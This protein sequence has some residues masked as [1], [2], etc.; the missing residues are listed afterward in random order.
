M[1][2]ARFPPSATTTPLST[3]V[4]PPLEVINHQNQNG[5]IAIIA[6]F[7]FGLVL[8]SASIKVF[9]RQYFR[10]FRH[11]DITF[12]IA[13]V[14]ARYSRCNRREACDVGEKN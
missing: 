13:I 4:I 9:A 12:A 1:S 10:N 5:V 2:I 6:G 11:D 8:L 7:S 3:S 14:R